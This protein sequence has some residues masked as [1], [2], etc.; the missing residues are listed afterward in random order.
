MLIKNT[1]SL[2][3]NPPLLCI[4]FRT[5]CQTQHTTSMMPP[6]HALC[7]PRLESLPLPKGPCLICAP[8]IHNSA[9]A[10][11]HDA[12]VTSDLGGACPAISNTKQAQARL[13]PLCASPLF[14]AATRPRAHQPGAGLFGLAVMCAAWHLGPILHSTAPATALL[15][16]DCNVAPL[17][18]NVVF[19]HPSLSAF[20]KSGPLIRQ[21]QPRG[22]GVVCDFRNGRRCWRRGER[23]ASCWFFRLSMRPRARA[24]RLDA[25][26]ACCPFARRRK[27]NRP[28]SNVSPCASQPSTFTHR[29]LSSPSLFNTHPAAKMLAR[30]NVAARPVAAKVSVAPRDPGRKGRRRC[31]PRPRRG[32]WDCACAAC[33]P[34]LLSHQHG[35]TVGPCVQ[36][37]GSQRAG[38]IGRER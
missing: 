34:W 29:A 33:D 1:S 12:R 15:I 6:C 17:F 32:P 3:S 23:R 4:R 36:G 30:T 9:G 13:W 31:Q 8:P 7:L 24:Q 35:G 20:V 27:N 19:K 2:C 11:H 28:A 38:E 25:A 21:P 18:C 37:R 14:V 10:P 22:L 26:G 5:L 16:C